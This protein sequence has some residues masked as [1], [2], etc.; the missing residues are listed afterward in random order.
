MRISDYEFNRMRLLKAI[1]RAEPVAR[2]DLVRITGLAAGTIT[3]LT[4]DLVH[5]KILTEGKPAQKSFGRPRVELQINAK[6]AHVVSVFA[7]ASN[8]Y[9]IEIV[10][11]RGDVVFGREVRIPHSRLPASWA[12]RLAQA[13]DATLR[14]GSVARADIARIGILI[15]GVVDN[16]KGVVHWL[17]TY[18]DRE[19][20]V[21]A[22]IEERLKIPV[23]ID[24]NTNLIARAEHWF[25]D[26]TERLDDFSVIV[27]DRG[28][29]SAHYV[30][31]MLWSGAQ[32]INS[33]LGHVKIMSDEG[34]PCYCGARGCLATYCSM[35][36]IVSRISELR[37]EAVPLETLVESF[38]DFA[39]QARRGDRLARKVFH[40]AGALLGTAAAN[41]LH[42][43][44]PRRLIVMA[45]DADF[46][47]LISDA[48][49]AALKSQ[50]L[51]AFAAKTEVQ[52]KLIDDVA[53]Y[54]KGCAVL[55]LEQIYL[56][57]I[58]SAGRTRK[59]PK[60]HDDPR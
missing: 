12:R 8:S 60:K 58:N 9:V 42:E 35:F 46:I 17:V 6:A 50:T 54:R 16:L 37:G 20:P 3:Q 33:E 49:Y 51:P 4:A 29:G 38:K 13:I 56:G 2:T 5:R 36:G 45:F 11:L 28:L 55:A 48:F 30:D 39:A 22:L 23:V 32:A 34:R 7:A 10:D 40:Q 18:P 53:Y 15:H 44:N 59:R 43:R 31:G 41:M 14:A 27:I 26:E 24:N 47:P 19:V 52:F 21:A 57:K 25:G 1:R